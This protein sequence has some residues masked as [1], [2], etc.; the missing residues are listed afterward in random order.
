MR[1]V[2]TADQILNKNIAP[3]KIGQHIGIE[4]IEPFG[5]HGG[6][7]FPP[8]RVGNTVGFDDMLVLGRPAG[9]F[10]GGHKQRAALAQG[11]LTGL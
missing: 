9:E 6:V 2:G 10:A 1:G 5:R 4:R 3:L 11:A 8:D 7:V